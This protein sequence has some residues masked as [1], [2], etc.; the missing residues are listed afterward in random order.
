MNTSQGADKSI[1]AHP[2][3]DLG[4]YKLQNVQTKTQIQF[5]KLAHGEFEPPVHVT[6]PV[7]QT[8]RHNSCAE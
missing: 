5:W 7:K 1:I 4:V 2:V 3:V 6:S 8:L